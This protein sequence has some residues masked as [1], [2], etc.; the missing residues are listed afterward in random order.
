[1]GTHS[2]TRRCESVSLDWRAPLSPQKDQSYH[3]IVDGLEKWY[4]IFS[5]NLDEAFGTRR[6]GRVDKAYQ[7]LTIAPALCDKLT[8]ALRSHLCAMSLHA[9][10]F[11]TAPNIAALDPENFQNPKSQRV[12]RY[13]G[14]L[15]R[16]ILTRRSQFLQKLS[17]L[18]EL[19]EDLGKSYDQCV[20]ELGEGFSSDSAHCWEMLDTS[21]YDLNTCLQETIVL[22]KCFLL[23]LPEKQL[24]EF[25]AQV[26]AQVFPTGRKTRVR[27]TF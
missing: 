3:F 12:A 7:I 2:S 10:H 18:T 8:A 25:Q 1:V 23:A 14:I 21:H 13:H 15:S 17:S 6:I 5:V 16:V 22:L 20:E 11:G 26:T 19:V 9:R 27:V 24:T 4:D